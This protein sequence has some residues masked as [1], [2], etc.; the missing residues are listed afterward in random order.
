MEQ[1]IDLKPYVDSLKHY[2]MWIVG[3]ALIAS[4]AA[5]VFSS[6]QAPVYEATSLVAVTQGNE[7]TVQ[8]D[9]RIQ[10]VTDSQ[11]I[12]A[13]PELATSDDFLL[14]IVPEIA[15]IDPRIQTVQSVRNVLRA[16]SGVDLS[17]L[18]LTA[19]ND[20]PQRAAAIVNVWANHFIN[21]VNTIYGGQGGEE[22]NFFE[23]QLEDASRQLDVAE[24]SL[25]DFQTRNRVPIITEQMRTQTDTLGDYLEKKRDITLL[26]QDVQSLLSL[27]ED[28]GSDETIS[29]QLASLLLH[30][31]AFSGTRPDMVL[32]LQLQLDVSQS[33]EATNGEQQ[34]V[35]SGLQDVLRI[36]LEQ[37]EVSIADLEPQIL[38]LQQLKQ[39][40]ETQVSE[41]NREVSVANETYMALA[42][43]VEAERITSQDTFG[44]VRIASAANTPES[45]ASSRL[46]NTVAAGIA[47]F[48]LGVIVVLVITWW[49]LYEDP[50]EIPREQA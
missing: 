24:Q 21:K 45:P 2:W 41:L 35:L 7:I 19:K 15:A 48:L 25:I 27:I 5:F 37:I 42:G 13:Y 22:L 8:F 36:Q 10:S 4:V 3:A 50:P 23:A 40:A 14:S 30:T 34:K 6:L 44:G 1:E 18:R 46:M 31:R 49:R 11:P 29:I 17:L 39:D 38:S 43:K 9:S 26:L 33:S 16:E 28:V 32:P 12:K 47:G 20:D